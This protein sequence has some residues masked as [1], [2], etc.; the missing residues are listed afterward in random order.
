MI[1]AL[2]CPSNQH[3]CFLLQK[4]VLC[5][6]SGVTQWLCSVCKNKNYDI[7]DMMFEILSI[8]GVGQKTSYHSRSFLIFC[9]FDSFENLALD[10]LFWRGVVTLDFF[11]E[12]K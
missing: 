12:R 4:C 11:Y 1:R 10:L 2:F 5:K 8:M 3:P 9:Y 7:T 6:N